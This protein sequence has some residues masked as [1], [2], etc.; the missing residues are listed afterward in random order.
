MRPG[1]RFLLALQSPTGGAEPFNW[2]RKK[3][4]KA[5]KLLAVPYRRGR[6]AQLFELIISLLFAVPYQ[7][8]GA[9]Q[10]YAPAR[11]F[12]L[13][14]TCS[15]QPAGRSWSTSMALGK[16]SLIIYLQSPTGWAEPVNR[17]M[18]IAATL[19]PSPCSPLPAGPSRSTFCD[20]PWKDTQHTCS[21]QP[22]GLSWS[23]CL[24]QNTYLTYSNLQSPTSR[25]EPLN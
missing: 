10:P 12:A 23:T 3:L 5:Y 2:I 1:D 25:E 9:A 11:Y 17:N 6:V 4:L 13:R 19:R 16:L 18:P 14:A 21:P 20:D 15:P 22:A 7:R 8:G 24:P